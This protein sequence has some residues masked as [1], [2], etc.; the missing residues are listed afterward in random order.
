MKA[1]LFFTGYG[2]GVLGIL[3]APVWWISMGFAGVAAACIIGL[4]I[5]SK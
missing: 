1:Y 5:E 2:F 3:F 4:A